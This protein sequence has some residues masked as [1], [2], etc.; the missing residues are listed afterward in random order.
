MT[1]QNRPGTMMNPHSMRNPFLAIG[2]WLLMGALGLFTGC[3]AFHPIDGIPVEGVPLEYRA[4]PRSDKIP[5]DLSRL[6]QTPPPEYRVAPG[7]LLGIFVEGVLG[8]DGELPPVTVTSQTQSRPALGYPILVQDDGTIALPLL[9]NLHV[10]GM[11][12]SEIRER[13]RHAY[14]VE[15]PQLREDAKPGDEALIMVD[16]P[17]K[18]N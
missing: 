3:A 4:E 9:P 1:Y 8:K 2:V 12:L 17:K 11:T 7:D 15:K 10:E 13:L 6:R 18:R 14:T 16:L 5:L